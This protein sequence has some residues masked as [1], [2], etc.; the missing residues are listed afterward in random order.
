MNDPVASLYEFLEEDMNKI[1]NVIQV[2]EKY[3]RLKFTIEQLKTYKSR[4]IF[5]FE[6]F[7][8][9]VIDFCYKISIQLSNSI[10]KE[11][12]NRLE[13][14]KEI[15]LKDFP[16]TN[17][18][19]FNFFKEEVSYSLRDTTL[20]LRLFYKLFLKRLTGSKILLNDIKDLLNIWENSL[21]SN[22]MPVKF[23]VNLK[24]IT[25]RQKIII[26]RNSI[27]ITKADLLSGI[28][29]DGGFNSRINCLLTFKTD[30][31]FFAY[32]SIKKRNS[33][34]I[35]DDENIKKNWNNIIRE[36]QQIVCTLYLCGLNFRYNSDII[37][38]ELPWWFELDE[39]GIKNK[40]IKG[41]SERRMLITREIAE[42][43]IK[44]YPKVLESEYFYKQNY[45]II[46]HNYINLFNRESTSLVM[47]NSMK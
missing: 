34:F 35:S 8:Q 31:M 47:E 21:S 7:R 42:D 3:K 13:L 44:F 39:E 19:S 24:N 33:N 12:S 32:K 9:L 22:S 27:M 14:F 5:N 38:I 23:I 40:L 45:I 46:Y 26:K 10:D 11:L 17:D 37:F 4:I 29:K 25:S 41:N 2:N 6:L 28:Y 30:V 18:I 1:I 16:N 15:F 36:L 20:F 43:I